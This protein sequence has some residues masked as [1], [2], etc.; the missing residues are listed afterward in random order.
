VAGDITIDT[1][2]NA[3][4]GEGGQAQLQGCMDSTTWGRF[5]HQQSE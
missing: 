1:F 2:W 4:G 3:H 5:W